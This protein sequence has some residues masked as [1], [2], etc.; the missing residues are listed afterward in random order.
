LE[1]H[2]VDRT[3]ALF[4]GMDRQRAGG[5]MIQPCQNAQQCAL[6][7]AA[8]PHNTD[9]L[10]VVDAQIDRPERMKFALVGGDKSFGELARLNDGQ[11]LIGHCDL[12]PDRLRFFYSAVFNLLFPIDGAAQFFNRSFSIAGVDKLAHVDWV[13]IAQLAL[14]G[15]KALEFHQ[16]LKRNRAIGVVIGAIGTTNH[17]RRNACVLLDN[18]EIFGVIPGV[19][20]E[21]TRATDIG[22]DK[23]RGKLWIGGRPLSLL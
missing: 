4:V 10:P 1:D 18:S 17:V 11:L 19:A 9:E 13:C 20:V 12:S 3:V 22:F 5:W 14:A 7:T 21:I 16:I 8:W 23:A 6:A 15:E 2:A